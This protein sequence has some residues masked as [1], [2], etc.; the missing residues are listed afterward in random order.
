MVGV[1]RQFHRRCQRSAIDPDV[2]DTD[3]EGMRLA[4]AKKDSE[5]I[6]SS[7]RRK[8]TVKDRNRYVLDDFCVDDENDK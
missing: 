5:D 8:S 3:R 4:K 7:K 6:S 1:C 2:D